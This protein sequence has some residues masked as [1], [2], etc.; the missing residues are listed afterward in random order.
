MGLIISVDMLSWIVQGRLA[1]SWP[2][3]TAPVTTAWT[4]LPFTH[5]IW[6][7]AVSLMAIGPIISWVVLVLEVLHSVTTG[8][9]N[10]VPARDVT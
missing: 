2:L 7:I 3:T 1:Q 4:P 5:Y 8:A 10:G 6:P 9:Q